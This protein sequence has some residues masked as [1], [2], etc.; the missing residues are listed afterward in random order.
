V[1]RPPGL[2]QRLGARLDG[3]L[4]SMEGQELSGRTSPSP[5]HR[6]KAGL[7]LAI[8]RRVQDVPGFVASLSS[9]SFRDFCLLN[10]ELEITAVHGYER[11]LTLLAAMKDRPGLGEDTT[12]CV[13]VE[14]MVHDERFHNLSFVAI[15]DWFAPDDGNALRPELSVE[16]CAGDVRGIR[17]RVYAT[18]HIASTAVPSTAAAATSA[19]ARLASSS[20]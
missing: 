10:A 18:D 16:A 3:F 11:M 9:L 20:E 13:D 8:G 1:A 15:G 12:L 17:A 6:V 4:G 19:S 5:L 2:W 7:M 14:R